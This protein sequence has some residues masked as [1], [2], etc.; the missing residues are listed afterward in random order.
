MS[1]RSHSPYRPRPA[2]APKVAPQ[3]R[4]TNSKTIPAN[5]GPATDVFSILAWNGALSFHHRSALAA[6]A[7]KA[8]ITE[9]FPVTLCGASDFLSTSTS[10]VKMLLDSGVLPERS[11][12]GVRALIATALSRC[13]TAPGPV[14]ATARQAAAPAPSVSELDLY[15]ALMKTRPLAAAKF[16]VE[17]KAKIIAQ[18]KALAKGK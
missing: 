10:T 3:L 11:L 7:C 8:A 18:G 6:C 17:N 4:A 12:K 14:A 15:R 13:P 1:I 9:R 16:W 2:S 5:R